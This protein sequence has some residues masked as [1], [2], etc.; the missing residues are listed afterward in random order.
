MNW[1][2]VR[3]RTPDL[4]NQ[5]PQNA[6]IIFIHFHHPSL[7]NGWCVELMVLVKMT[8][9]KTTTPYYQMIF[10]CQK[11]LLGLAQFN[12]TIFQGSNGNERFKKILFHGRDWWQMN[13][14][15]ILHC[16]REQRTFAIG[17]RNFEI[18]KQLYG[19]FPVRIR[20][21]RLPDLKDKKYT[22]KSNVL[23]NQTCSRTSTVW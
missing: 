21:I 1:I 22:V 19:S 11:I 2:H 7:Q 9:N 17:S 14:E 18:I 23:K 20:R 12:R 15:R 8:G 10:P 6:E 4:T 13:M 5:W 16:Q 3:S